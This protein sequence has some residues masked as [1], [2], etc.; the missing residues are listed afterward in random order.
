MQEASLSPSAQ[1]RLHGLDFLRALMMLLGVVLHSAQLYLTMPIIDYYWDPARS[2]SMDA[3]LIFIN[4]FRMPVFFLLAGFFMAMLLLRRGE[5]AMLENRYQRLI[6]PFV[7][8]LP[9][10]ALVMTLLRIVAR[11][12]ME[13]GEFGFD[14]GLV[15]NP[16][17]IWDNTH[18]LWFLY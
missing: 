16:R 10:L 17:R 11:H 18:N 9:P 14:P 7:L 1:Q 13:T 8:F 5:Q 4:T 15:Y 6:V 2:F 12:I 3:I